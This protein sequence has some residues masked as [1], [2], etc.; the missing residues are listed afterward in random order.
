[1]T[2]ERTMLVA[3]LLSCMVLLVAAAVIM[4]LRQATTRALLSR[5][6]TVV[7]LYSRVPGGARDAGTGS[8]VNILRLLGER[9]RNSTSLYSADDIASLEGMLVAGGFKPRQMLPIVLGAKAAFFFL[10]VVGA[11]LYGFITELAFVQSIVVIALA[12]P[13]GL[14]VPEL[15]L[16]LL[17]RPYVNALQ[18]GVSDALDL[19]VVCSEAGMGLESGLNEVARE[20]Q[21]SNPAIAAALTTFLDELRVL[22]DRREAFQNFGRRSGVDGIR[23]MATLLGQT[24][25]Y[26]TPL[27]QSLRAMANQLRREQMIRLEAKAV[28]LPALLVFPLIAFIMPSLF[29]VLMGP[30]MMRLFD[31]LQLSIGKVGG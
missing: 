18:R 13:I 24:L 20:M 9:I 12:L 25:Q 10:I 26:G 29:I 27:G 31:M 7:G 22:P 1:M 19:L 16:R 6:Q 15:A 3:A 14:M 21:Y 28:R 17:R 23:R 5:V 2:S 11:I 8:P 4:L 30:S